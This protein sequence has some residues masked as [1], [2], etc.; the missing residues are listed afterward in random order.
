MTSA[1]SPAVRKATRRFTPKRG[2]PTQ[3]QVA[4]ID[5]VILTVARTMFLEHGYASTSMEA[6]AATAGVSKG[7]LY[8]RYP[9]KSDL[10]EAIAAERMKTW[11]GNSHQ[12]IEVEGTT[13]DEYLFRYGVLV[14]EALRLPE[15]AAFDRLIMTEASRFPE[16]A[17]AFHQQGYLRAIDQTAQAISRTA[18]GAGRPVNDAEGLAAAFIYG[19]LGWHRAV[20]LLRDVTEQECA[21]YVRRLLSIFM[22]GRSVW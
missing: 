6:V 5:E 7:T 18:G 9:A 4:A 3:E 19:L 13:V 22:G 21:E 10:F 16:L 12:A 15:I 2:R 14:L 1:K 8:S 20:G 17:K 11:E